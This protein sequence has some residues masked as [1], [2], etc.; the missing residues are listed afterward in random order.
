MEQIS[1]FPF[2]EIKEC[3]YCGSVGCYDVYGDYMCE[4]CF[5]HLDRLESED[6]E[7]DY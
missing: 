7:D 2:Y 4:R 1:Q 6:D 5:I 3:N